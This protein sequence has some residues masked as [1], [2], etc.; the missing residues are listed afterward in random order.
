MVAAELPCCRS[1]SGSSS[2]SCATCSAG[3]RRGAVLD[4]TRTGVGEWAAQ[5]C[6]RLARAATHSAKAEESAAQLLR[7]AAVTPSA[8]GKEGRPRGPRRRTDAAADAEAELAIAK[9][10]GRE[11]VEEARAYRERVLGELSK[12]RDLAR[13]QIEHLIHGRERLLQAFERARLVAADVLAEMTPIEEP[14]E[15]VDL[16]PTTGPVPI[17]VPTN[18]LGDA[19]S[20]DVDALRPPPDDDVDVKGEVVALRVVEPIEDKDG[21][22]GVDAEPEADDDADTDIAH[23]FA[24]LRAARV[25]EPEESGAGD[26]ALAEDT[27]FRQRD[28]TVVPLFVA[29]ARKLK[30]VLADEQNDVLDAMRRG[31]PGPHCR[32]ILPAVDEQAARYAGGHR[33]RARRSGSGRR[34]VHVARTRR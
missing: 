11:M 12:R 19:S 13:Q 33:W 27:P 8:S 21:Q 14:E 22:D 3:R 30:R 17:M 23:L 5:S 34:R 31:L 28:A 20:I 26:V 24:S 9:Q 18:R 10:Q 1:A 4:A 7:E 2:A 25:D 15:F 32:R 6:T 29:G 16:S